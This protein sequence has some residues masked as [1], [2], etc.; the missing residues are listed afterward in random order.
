MNPVREYLNTG[1]PLLFDGAMGTYYAHKTKLPSLS[2]EEACLFDPHA[3]LEIH[4]EYL[5][6]G[7]DAIKTNTFGISRM[8]ESQEEG[9][10]RNLTDA[11]I[12]LAKEAVQGTSAFVFGDLGPVNT[13]NEEKAASLY[14]KQARWF[15]EQGISCL[16]METLSSMTGV[17]TF[18]RSLKKE[19]PNCFLLVSYAVSPEGITQDGLSGKELYEKT[20]ALKEVD[21]AGFNCMS[22]P[23]HLKQ[24]VQ[25][26]QISD[27]PL[28]VLPN[29]GYPTVLGRKVVYPTGAE[30]FAGQMMEIVQSGASMIGGCCGTTP[31]H[32]QA[33]SDVLKNAPEICTVIR[34]SSKTAREKK[35]DG[36]N[37][38]QEKL[39]AGKKIIAVELDPPADDHIEPFME[40]AAALKKAG[41]DAVTIADSPVGRPR[42]D[43]SLIACRLKRELGI[44]PLPHM[45][46][47]DR[48]LIATKALLLGLS[49]EGIHNVLLVTGDPVPSAERSEVR[50][51]FNFN[52]RK[53]ARYV[54][55]A[56]RT[57]FQTPFC[58]YGALN[59]NAVNFDVQLRIAR[60]KEESGV[61]VFM[62]QPVLSQRAL[63]N[64]KRARNELSAK[65]LAGI[66][67]VISERNAQFL[68]NEVSGV[69]VCCEIMDL[70]KG[71]SREESE[72]T[73]RK[74]S[75][76]I[77][78]QVLPYCDGLYLMTPFRR[79][80]LMEQI[81]KDAQ[82][83][84]QEEKKI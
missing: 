9:S 13:D 60:E 4:Q 68:N 17:E 72:E 58:I 24:F 62:T 48:N 29:A 55:E 28:S 44:D 18:A 31:D 47:R 42:A 11:A 35:T 64:L 76:E 77:M 25:T 51:V 52:S 20:A 33:V 22:G 50:S 30:Y 14:L 70:Y 75:R 43:S 61:S 84:M 39:N 19:A 36:Q 69:E 7:A 15:L 2:V 71:K 56:G 1:R 73:A 82:D 41:V 27:K 16:I 74:I 78:A 83:L 38:L 59:L 37:R 3:V 5:Q 40:A 66:F 81:I 12:L 34:N 49:M 80:S 53:L 65:I 8:L 32:I 6:A 67:P 26:L 54:S 10:A 21:A 57:L 45:A 23:L 79:V 63:E 46:C